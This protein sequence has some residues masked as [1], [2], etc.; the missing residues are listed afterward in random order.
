MNANLT[1]YLA[2]WGATLSTVTVIWNFWRSYR[3]RPHIAVKIQARESFEDDGFG[4]IM[5]ELR[6]RGGKPT[7]VE[8]IKLVKYAPGG[9]GLLGHWDFSENTW[10]ASPKTV[11]LPVVLKPGEV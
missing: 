1:A 4:A 9:W 7:T 2:A 5:F 8:E 6:N 11:K 10:V 3:E